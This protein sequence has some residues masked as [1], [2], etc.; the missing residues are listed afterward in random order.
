MLINTATPL[1]KALL[2]ERLSSQQMIRNSVVL[3]AV[4]SLLL[5]SYLMFGFYFAVV[6]NIRAFEHNASKL[7][8][9]I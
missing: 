3:A 8:K 4:V 1:L 5:A 7:H 9:V 2:N 6:D